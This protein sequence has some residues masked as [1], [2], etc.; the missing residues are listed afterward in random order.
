MTEC[1]AAALE[2]ADELKRYIA[3]SV[4]AHG[5]CT[6]AVNPGDRIPFS[7]P[8]HPESYYFHVAASEW[9]DCE[10]CEISGEQFAMQIADTSAGLFGRL[11]QLWYEARAIDR[12]QL[13]T[14]LIEGVQPLLERQRLIGQ[15]LERP[16]RFAG[17]ISELSPLELLKLLYSPDRD[18][19]NDARRE[20]E[21]RASVGLYFPALI[22]VLADSTHPY[23]RSAQW[24]ALD[25]FEDLG[26]FARNE[27]DWKIAVDHIRE[28]IWNAQD[29]YARAIY[30]AG[31]VLGGHMPYWHG[32]RA[33]VDCLKAPSRIGRRSA[34]HGMYHLAEWAPEHRERILDHLAGVVSH[35]PEP[36]LRQYAAVMSQDIIRAD[37]VH[38]EDV[39]FPHEN[40]IFR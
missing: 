17:R 5:G 40:Q 10:P 35:D 36:V 30:K 26:S 18:V 27:Q 24:A 25:L 1:P 14:K 34:I 23:R 13:C 16:G 38:A 8:P 37:T 7:W 39:E 11:P 12:D 28:L 20:I 32:A 31:V 29:D 21:T 19:T 3:R 9:R 6:A 15:V 33:L 4:Q 22:A 2:L